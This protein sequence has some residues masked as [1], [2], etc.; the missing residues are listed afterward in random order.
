MVYLVPYMATKYDLLIQTN[1]NIFNVDDLVAIWQSAKRRDALESVKGY[2]RRGKIF[3]L[4]KGIYSLRKDF[5]NFELAQKL[6]TPSYISYYS[7]LALHGIIF[8][9]Y[10][11]IHLCALDSKVIEINKRKFIY[12]KIKKS[13]LYNQRG[14]SNEKNY[15]IASP[16][17]AIC[18]S[19][20]LNKN[21]TFD[22]LRNLEREKMIAISKIYQ[23]KRLERDIEELFLLRAKND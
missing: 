5:D 15:L 10:S 20:Y 2:I 14:F 3:N 4:Y 11:D 7:A 16:E 18:D 9:K 13:I 1:K 22:N 6:F 19:L 17:R 12:H 8:Q 23:N 21:I